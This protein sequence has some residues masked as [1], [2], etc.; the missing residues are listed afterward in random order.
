MYMGIYPSVHTEK[1][2]VLNPYP[3]NP[4]R[5]QYNTYDDRTN[6]LTAG[7][8]CVFKSMSV[9]LLLHSKE[10][11]LPQDQTMTHARHQ[12]R[13]RYLWVHYRN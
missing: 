9:Q 8:V 1:L 3:D 10:E 11:T 6:L 2:L 7:D 13:A 5:H 4:D 12:T